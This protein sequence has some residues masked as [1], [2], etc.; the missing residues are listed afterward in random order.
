VQPPPPP[1]SIKDLLAASK[2]QTNKDSHKNKSHS[3]K[4][5]ILSASTK[6]LSESPSGHGGFFDLDDYLHEDDS[7]PEWIIKADPVIFEGRKVFAYKSQD[8]RKTNAKSHIEVM[9][10]KPVAAGQQG[11]QRQGPSTSFDQQ[12]KYFRKTEPEVLFEGPMVV[13]RKPKGHHGSHNK[14]KKAHNEDRRSI[15]QPITGISKR[16]IGKNKSVVNP[17]NWTGTDHFPSHRYMNDPPVAKMPNRAV[18]IP[19]RTLMPEGNRRDPKKM[20]QPATET[21]PRQV[22]R[23]YKDEQPHFFGL[24]INA[25]N[26]SQK[27]SNKGH[28]V[29]ASSAVQDNK[30]G[31]RGSTPPPEEDPVISSI[32]ECIGCPKKDQRLWKGVFKEITE[33]IKGKDPLRIKSLMKNRYIDWPDSVLKW[34]ADLRKQDE[35][36]KKQGIGKRP[37]R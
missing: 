34:K 36:M 14:D 24:D 6:A 30:D 23:N 19:Q 12:S 9:N 35:A 16:D 17:Y 28:K 5:G 8:L 18:A 2:Q 33:E 3:P 27:V 11:Q 32:L 1:L 13:K 22:F 10:S 25:L 15:P 20:G 7:Q 29:G 21:I 26:Q 31:Q 4:K 37:P